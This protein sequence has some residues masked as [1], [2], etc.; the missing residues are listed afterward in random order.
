MRASADVCDYAVTGIKAVHHDILAGVL[1]ALECDYAES[2]DRAPNA[3]GYEDEFQAV[4]KDTS[5]L[6]A[7][8]HIVL[9][10]GKM[11]N[12]G[13]TYSSSPDSYPWWSTSH[14]LSSAEGRMQKGA[15]IRT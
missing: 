6:A 9:A 1:N 14:V 2:V 5:R 7:T 10:E 4:R 11:H 8:R 3:G 15:H 12:C 13:P